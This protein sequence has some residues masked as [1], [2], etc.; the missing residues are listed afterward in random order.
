[1][2]YATA[3]LLVAAVTSLTTVAQ[4]AEAHQH[5][6]HMAE[7]LS[8]ETMATIYTCTKLPQCSPMACSLMR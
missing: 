3:L 4:K 5:G 8:F 7:E 2:F 6:R 1:M